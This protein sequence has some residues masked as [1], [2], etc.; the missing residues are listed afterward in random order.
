LTRAWLEQLEPDNIRSVFVGHFQ[1][2][3]TQLENSW[4]LC[5]Y[6]Q[7]AN[8]TLQ[9]YI[10]RFSKKHNELPNIINTGLINAFICVMT[11][12][13]LVHALR[14]ETPCMTQELLDITT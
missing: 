4:D 5:N 8:E 11:C 6:R 12:K 3:H 14:R 10:Q 2:M 7:R 13:V 1:G 9:E